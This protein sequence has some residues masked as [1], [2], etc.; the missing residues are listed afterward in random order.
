[1]Y[2]YHR[3]HITWGFLTPLSSYQ[4]VWHSW[5]PIHPI[6]YILGG[7]KLSD[8]AS[9]TGKALFSAT[10]HGSVHPSSPLPWQPLCFTY[11]KTLSSCIPKDQRNSVSPRLSLFFCLSAPSFFSLHFLFPH[12]AS[13]IRL[14]LDPTVTT[15]YIQGLAFP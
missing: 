7:K 8:P 4:D 15:C 2:V 5:N 14:K 6:S 3:S 9:P 11:F 10:I 13:L 1:M 12:F